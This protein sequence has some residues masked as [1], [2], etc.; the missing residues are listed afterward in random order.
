V[1]RVARAVRSGGVVAYPTEGVYGIGCAA[2]NGDAGARLL[3]LKGRDAGQGLIVIA[4]S[5]EQLD[6]WIEPFGE[7]ERRRVGTTWPGPVTW[8]VPA[9]AGVPDW[10]TGGRATLAVRVTAHP[11]ASA[12]CAAAGVA[13]VSTSANRHGHPPACNALTVRR[14]FGDGLDDLLVGGCGPLA[15]PTEIRDLRSGRVLRP[16][17]AVLA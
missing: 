1:S 15:G 8:V 12:L 11:L 3:A 5:L 16:P 14:I 6:P 2:D 4:A 10:L 17:P 7:A 13:L 9:R